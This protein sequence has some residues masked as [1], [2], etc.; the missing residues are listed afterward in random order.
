M[1]KT[2]AIVIF[3][4]LKVLAARPCLACSCVGPTPVCSVYWKTDVL[5]LGHVIRIEHAGGKNLVH[6]DVTKSYRGAPGEQAVIQTADQGSACGYEFEQGHD[7]LVFAYLASNG[8]LSASHCTRTHEVTNRA[9]D[10]DIQWIEGLAKAPPGASIFGHIQSSRPNELGGYDADGLPDIT[11]SITG[12]K[13]TIAS[14]DTDGKYRADGLAPG[15][16][17]VSA[18]APRRYAAF[19]ELTVT[20]QDRGCAAV[21]FST[22]LDGHIRGHVY[23]SD[24]TPAEGVYLTAKLADSQPHEPWTWQAHYATTTSDGSFD[25]AELA[26]GSYVFAANMDFSPVTSKGTAYYRRAFFPSSGHRSEAAVITV[27]AGQMVD[28]LRFFLPPDAP[29]PSIPLEVTVLGFDGRPVS[30]A[31]ILAYDDIWE[32]PVTPLMASADEHGKATVT[33]RPGSHY[34]IEALAT[35]PDSSQDCAEPLG[36]DA[37]GQPAPLVLVLS[38]HIG[39]CTPF[40]KPRH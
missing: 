35:L 7:Y 6:F 18:V 21:D 22:R 40:R 2:V 16:Y 9:D 23:F 19:P 8:D 4:I 28:H 36:V 32:N 15:K 26:A 30:H 29:P 13:S 12:P 37:H 25:F 20:V 5:F 33:L 14:S 34:D 11:V 38:H 39:N 10:E 1:S 27:D 24:G 17:T 3:V 31:Q